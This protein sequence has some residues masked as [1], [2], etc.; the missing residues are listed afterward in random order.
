MLFIS[1]INVN[2]IEGNKKKNLTALE[3]EGL[4]IKK[5]KGFKVEY[6]DNNFAKFMK[7]KRLQPDYCELSK[8][9]KGTVVVFKR[10]D[11]DKSELIS[12]GDNVRYIDTYE[13]S[14]LILTATDLN[15][16]IHR[17]EEPQMKVTIQDNT[18][19]LI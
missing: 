10:N 19:G 17:N 9:A 2:D 14:K 15:L 12:V 3:I 6:E 4:K 7:V 8:D 18:K 13:N 1:D 11:S 16:F 5:R